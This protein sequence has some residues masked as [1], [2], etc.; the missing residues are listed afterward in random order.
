MRAAGLL[1]LLLLAAPAVAPAAEHDI[2]WFEANPLARQ[3]WLHR[4]GNDFRLA[5]SPICGNAEKAE[6]RAYA[7]R[8]ARQ[9]GLRS[10]PP[11]FLTPAVRG[12]IREGCR[13]P[14]AERGLVAPY[15]GRT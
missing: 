2:P 13:R 11:E 3:E 6:Q 9:S 7:K 1:A 15:C 12:A 5:R 14:V 4:C 10:L 8:L